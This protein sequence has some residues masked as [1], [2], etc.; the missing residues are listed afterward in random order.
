MEFKYN[1]P[2]KLW[3]IIHKDNDIIILKDKA[4]DNNKNKYCYNFSDKVWRTFEFPRE[5][6]TG[7]KIHTHPSLS[8]ARQ[9]KRQENALQKHY[10]EV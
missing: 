5:K 10:K 8:P 2:N 6:K 3:K 9:I 4:K 7:H 1:G